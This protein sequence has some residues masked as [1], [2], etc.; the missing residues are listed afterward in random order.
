MEGN[1]WKIHVNLNIDHV[2]LSL[3]YISS[4]VFYCLNFCI[5]SLLNAFI[6]FIGAA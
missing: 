2:F 6:N 5:Y 3:T 1:K 4:H